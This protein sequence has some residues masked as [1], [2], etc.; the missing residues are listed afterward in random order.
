MTTPDFAAADPVLD[1]VAAVA[2]AVL[3]EGYLL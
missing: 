2:D 1:Q 3:F